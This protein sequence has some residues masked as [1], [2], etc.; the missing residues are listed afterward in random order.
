MVRRIALWAARQGLE[1]GGRRR[2]VRHA[3]RESSRHWRAISQ[4]VDEGL[5]RRKATTLPLQRS[6]HC[7]DALLDRATLWIAAR[8][9][10]PSPPKA[11]LLDHR[12]LDK[13][14]QSTRFGPSS[15]RESCSRDR[16]REG[17]DEVRLESPENLGIEHRTGRPRD[18]AFD[19]PALTGFSFRSH[20]RNDLLPSR[21]IIGRQ[22]CRE[23]DDSDTQSSGQPDLLDRHRI[24]SIDPPRIEPADRLGGALR[25]R[26]DAVAVE[27]IDQA[28]GRP[29]C[30][31]EE[32]QRQRQQHGRRERTDDPAS[33][34]C[35]MNDDLGA[36][37]GRLLVDRPQR[38]R[39]QLVGLGI[40]G[41]ARRHARPARLVEPA[42]DVGRQL[43]EIE[44]VAHAPASVVVSPPKSAARKSLADQPRISRT[45]SQVKPRASNVPRIDARHRS[46]W[47]YSP[48]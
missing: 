30:A 10:G 19:R 21:A 12:I 35:R 47:L 18:Q 11:P 48:R 17:A 3:V 45:C 25:Q 29:R 32:D 34:G 20:A 16:T 4:N 8:R 41:E 2:L 44:G 40:A 24:T 13:C 27:A 42:F 9:P 28:L 6:S 26:R 14:R 1:P 7:G 31:Q 46:L 5:E 39:E 37:L 23:I 36:A 33:V 38:R 15:Q 22:R 43:L